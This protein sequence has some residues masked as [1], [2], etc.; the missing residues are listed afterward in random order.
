[1][2]AIHHDSN[3][4]D[5]ERRDELWRG[6]IFV[7]SPT[8][9]S[10][11]LCDLARTMLGAAF[12]GEPRHIDKRLPVEETVAVLS[13]LKPS[14]IHHPACKTLLPDILRELGADLDDTYFDVPRLRSAYPHDY[15]SAGIAY[16]FHP[17]RDTWYSAP[18]CQI[19][20][21]IPVYDLVA[22]NAM[23]FY[24][25]HFAHPLANNSEV[26]NYQRW[27]ETSRFQAAQNIKVDTRVQPMPQEPVNGPEV[28]LLP[29]PGSIIV[30]AG[31][32]LHA[33]VENTSGVARYSIDF[34]AVNIKDVRE[35]R[36]APNIDSKCTGTTMRD[37]FR[38]SDLSH[39]PDDVIALY[40]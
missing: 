13:K 32:Q 24:P 34:R 7:Y 2:V 20:L 1:M 8:A 23:A 28:V 30:F 3:M 10:L 29:K 27:N 35:R 11:K 4:S 9:S 21:W 37:Y 6:G 19:N 17:H 15:L 22:T 36:G 33:T 14:F 5:D 38:G 26:Y 40:E 25:H 12:D 16:A 39:V 18:Q 31:A